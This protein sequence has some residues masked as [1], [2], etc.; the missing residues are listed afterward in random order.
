MASIYALRAFVRRHKWWQNAV[1]FTG[2]VSLITVFSVAFLGAD[3][4]PRVVWTN[5]PLGP[6][7]RSQ[8]AS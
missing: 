6:E 3:G 1:F 2:L 5:Q 8:L 7:Y 4:A